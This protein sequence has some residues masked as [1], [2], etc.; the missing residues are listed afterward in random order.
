MDVAIGAFSSPTEEI[1]AAASYALGSVSAGNLQV[2]LPVIPQEIEAK[3]RRHAV[4]PVALAQG[5]KGMKSGG[6]EG[7]GRGGR[8]GEGR[9]SAV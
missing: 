2:Y 3:P 1:R 6:G 9:S 8:G 5:G 4:P 7:E